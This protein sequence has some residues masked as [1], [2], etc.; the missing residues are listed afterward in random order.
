MASGRE[1]AGVSVWVC[2]DGGGHIVAGAGEAAALSRSL[3]REAAIGARR[4]LLLGEEIVG[5]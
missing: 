3:G 2:S 5:A 1:G 4:R